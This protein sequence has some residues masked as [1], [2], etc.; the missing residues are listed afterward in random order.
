MVP[1]RQQPKRG[2]GAQLATPAPPELDGP[3]YY[4]IVDRATNKVVGVTSEKKP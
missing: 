4:E 2:L 3:Y 1:L